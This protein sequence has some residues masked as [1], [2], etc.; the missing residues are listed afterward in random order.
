MS[1]VDERFETAIDDALGLLELEGHKEKFKE[2]G[3]KVK[4]KTYVDPWSGL[5]I[6]CGKIKG[7]DW[8][9]LTIQMPDERFLMK[10]KLWNDDTYEM[11]VFD[12]NISWTWPALVG[13]YH[14]RT[15]RKYGLD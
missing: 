10:V 11:L 5:I 8:K 1:R 13:A 6:R 7:R 14:D 3:K 9:L 12:T 4:I 15:R 2:N